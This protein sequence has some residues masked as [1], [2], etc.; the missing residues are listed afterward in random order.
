MLYPV[1]AGNCTALIGNQAILKIFAIFLP[2]ANSSTSL[3]KY[4]TFFVTGF[5]ISSI[6]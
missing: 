5:S 1:Q 6:R 4:R 2:L 3:S